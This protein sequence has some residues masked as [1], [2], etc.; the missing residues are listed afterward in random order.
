MASGKTLVLGLGNTILSDDAVGIIV[1]RKIFERLNDPQIDFTEASYAGWRLVDILAGYARVVIIDSVVGSGGRIGECCKVDVS[2]N[3]SFHLR[4]SHGL[5]LNDAIALA[6]T[7]GHTMPD[8]VSVYAIEV[9]N[10]YEFGE[11]LTPGVEEEIPRV[12]EQIIGEEFGC[13]DGSTPF[14]E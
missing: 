2:N 12:V 14:R 3:P 9:S 7:S 1:A 13:L 6:K 11:K 4:A 5:G 10:P 8:R